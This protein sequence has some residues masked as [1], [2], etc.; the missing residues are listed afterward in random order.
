MERKQ[1]KSNGLSVVSLFSG[2]GGLDLG[3]MYSGYNVIWAN[4][5]DKN[6]VKTYKNNIGSNIIEGD[7]T[8]LYKDIPQSDVLIGGFPCQPFS[9]MGKQQ[10]F[11]DERGTLFF[12]IQ[13]IIELH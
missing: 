12:T 9:M 10:G 4:D 11:N 2:I 8:K 7:I 6:A 5:F 1:A 13:Q 3:F